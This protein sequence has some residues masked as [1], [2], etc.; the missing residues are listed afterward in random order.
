MKIKHIESQVETY[1]KFGDWIRQYVRKGI[2]NKWEVVSLDGVYKVYT[3]RD[4]GEISITLMS[5]SEANKHKNLFSSKVRI[6]KE[7][8]TMEFYKEYLETKILKNKNHLPLRKKNWYNLPAI[9]AKLKRITKSK[10]SKEAWFMI[11]GIIIIL[12]ATIIIA[13][14]K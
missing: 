6:S 9:K 5:K 3:V 7:K 14:L 12:I 11:R 13:A 1:L 2:Y 4:N 8:V 10:L